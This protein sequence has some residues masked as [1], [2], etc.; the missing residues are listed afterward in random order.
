MHRKPQAVTGKN[1][2]THEPE[3]FKGQNTK[4]VQVKP[5]AQIQSGGIVE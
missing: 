1:N 2:I 4:P 5:T 3:S